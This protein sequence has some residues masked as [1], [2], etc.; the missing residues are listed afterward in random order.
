MR[1]RARGCACMRACRWGE[2]E[3]RRW[4]TWPSWPGPSAPAVV[5]RA[6]ARGGAPCRRARRGWREA[7]SIPRASARVGH[8]AEHVWRERAC[9]APRCPRGRHAARLE[10]NSAASRMRNGLLTWGARFR[11]G[12]ASAPT[13][14]DR[15]K[16]YVV[17]CSREVLA[18]SVCYLRKIK[19][20]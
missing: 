11:S 10:R 12:A 15:K 1:A 8:A 3:R 16:I 7:K 17:C 20:K 13:S 2:R 19:K 14:S 4:N 9:D 6:L 5:R 18:M